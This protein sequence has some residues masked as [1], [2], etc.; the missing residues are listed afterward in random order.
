MRTLSAVETAPLV[1]SNHQATPSVAVWQQTQSHHDE[2]GS[3]VYQITVCL[4]STPAQEAFLNNYNP[5][6]KHLSITNF[7]CL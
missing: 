3:E 1:C 6:N 2:F 5:E 7:T 4:F